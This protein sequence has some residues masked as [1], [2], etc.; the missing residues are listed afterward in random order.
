M[1][2]WEPLDQGP[3]I[4]HIAKRIICL[5]VES[6]VSRLESMKSSKLKELVLKKRLELENVCRHAHMTTEAF[7]AM[8]FSTEDIESRKFFCKFLLDPIVCRI[9]SFLVLS[10]LFFRNHKP[11]TTL[12]TK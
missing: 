5:Q 9:A 3:F 4:F 10:L 12:G 6:E 8:E 2:F 1:L 7:G 11:Y